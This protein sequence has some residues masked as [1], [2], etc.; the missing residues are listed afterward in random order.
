MDV[1]VR[2]YS[3]DTARLLQNAHYFKLMGRPQLALQALEEAHQQDPGNLKA[4]NTLAEHYEGVG[5]YER[6]RQV[7]QEALALNPHNPVLNNNLCFSYYLEGNW[8]Q[9]EAGFRKTLEQQPDNQAARNN[10]GL[11][12]C[13][14]GRQEEARRLWQKQG[15]VVAD[16]MLDQALA[17]L[18]TART[19]PVAQ[20]PAP[21]RPRVLAREVP[22]PLP[23]G[24]LKAA[25]GT[26]EKIVP[27]QVN[28]SPAPG[29]FIRPAAQADVREKVQEAMAPRQPVPAVPVARLR[30]AQP[31]GEAAARPIPEK[32]PAP[33]V[34]P[35]PQSVEHQTVAVALHKATPSG[36]PSL[37]ET[38]PNRVKTPEA[39]AVA[40]AAA[41][42]PEGRKAPLGPIT[43]KELVETQ[44]EIR[45]GN[46]IHDLAH[47]ARS[48]LSLEG[49]NVVFIGNHIDFGM[50]RTVV[51][52]R[53]EAEKVA[54][55]LAGRF[56]PEAEI[57]PAQ[58]LKDPIDVQIVLGQDLAAEKERFLAR[59][60]GPANKL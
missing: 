42:R 3:G 32:V 39:K 13:R 51:F 46:G 38:R 50:E 37:T 8:T 12:L 17:A 55:L 22:K 9:A 58:K 54:R 41:V 44:I 14:Q 52:Y 27:G 6:A 47:E 30:Q 59:G 24:A 25:P 18:G 29:E 33:V 10:L 20:Q 11:L 23:V 4:A 57:K 1:K 31:A 34:R 35:A 28:S 15:E 53:P 43:A 19:I 48:L 2:P 36:G 56:F 26:P 49:F 45:N 16:R 21:A 7:Y 60:A 5:Q 40:V